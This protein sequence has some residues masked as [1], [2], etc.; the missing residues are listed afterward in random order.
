M[1]K[2]KR[3][4]GRLFTVAQADQDSLLAYENQILNGLDS[5][6]TLEAQLF[7][8]GISQQDSL[9][10]SEQ[11]LALVDAVYLAGLAKTTLL[12]RIDSIRALDAGDLLE[13]NSDL[14]DLETPYA[15]NEKAVNDIL[16]R[17]V[18]SGIFAFPY[19]IVPRWI[20]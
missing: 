13:Q 6:K 5:L 8:P 14:P 16:L 18:A 12:H 11:R 10:W 1:R 4:A 7:S 9:V 20:P 15:A 19:R 3:P 17:T 2:Y